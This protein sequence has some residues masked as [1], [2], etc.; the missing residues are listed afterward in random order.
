MYSIE[1]DLSDFVNRAEFP[2]EM[3]SKFAEVG[4]N[5]LYMKDLLK[6]KLSMVESG[7]LIYSM[8]KVDA[9]IVSFLMVHS[10]LGMAT[11]D[12]LGSEE[13]AS[14]ILPDAL[15]LK[16][17]LCVA[18]AEKMHGSD[19]TSMKTSAKK[20]DGG[21]LINGHK[22]WIQNATVADYIIVWARNE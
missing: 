13:Q 22:T 12:K 11:I 8:G 6:T 10:Y 16:K 1:K 21:W 3:L 19:A 17:I 18:M 7:S 15:K 9:S 2:I 4:M 20:V 5:N 14:R